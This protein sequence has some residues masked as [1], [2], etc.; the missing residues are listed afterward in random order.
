MSDPGLLGAFRK[1]V[2][3][4]IAAGREPEMLLLIW[5][6]EPGTTRDELIDILKEEGSK[7]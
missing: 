3:T 6:G 4:M 2:R 5:D 1:Q 7:A